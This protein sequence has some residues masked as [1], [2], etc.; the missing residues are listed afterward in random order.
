MELS[1]SGRSVGWNGLSENIEMRVL[2]VVRM[3]DKDNGFLPYSHHMQHKINSLTSVALTPNGCVTQHTRVCTMQAYA[4]SVC[5]ERDNFTPPNRMW[6]TSRQ[7]FT[8]SFTCN[9]TSMF[10]EFIFCLIYHLCM[11][12]SIMRDCRLR[13][14]NDCVL[15]RARDISLRLCVPTSVS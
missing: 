1:F 2:A 4:G 7:V 11:P 10:N 9:H 8:R 5:C 12:R 6:G 3:F 14:V 13:S 15:Q